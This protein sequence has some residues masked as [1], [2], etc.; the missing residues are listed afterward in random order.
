MNGSFE[1][2]YVRFRGF[3]A[4]NGYSREPVWITRKDVLLSE[5]RLLYV[6]IPLPNSN[7]EHAR[8]IFETAMNRYSGVSFSAVCETDHSTL[9]T[10][11]AP[12]DESDRQYA[13]CPK[14]GLKM[15][16][17]TVESRVRTKEVR[18]SLFWWYLQFR[19][20]KNEALKDPL[21]WG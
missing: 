15:S 16:A 9:C 13:M 5:R 4:E 20:R 6:K 7:R 8:V 17:R 11:W 10:A 1:E 21:F 14:T 12:A 19:Y 18:S 2:S 3:L